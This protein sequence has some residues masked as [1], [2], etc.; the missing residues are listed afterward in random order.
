MVLFNFFFTKNSL[1]F[2][3]KAHYC[4][5]KKQTVQSIN[6]QTDN[7]SKSSLTDEGRI[8]QSV[9]VQNLKVQKTYTDY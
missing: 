5:M 2:C 1:F 9:P 7:V 8:L 4:G 3:F 6:S